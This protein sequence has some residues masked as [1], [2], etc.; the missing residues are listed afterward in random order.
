MML[1]AV[2]ATFEKESLASLVVKAFVAG[3]QGVLVQSDSTG[4]RVGTPFDFRNG[5]A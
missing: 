2:K 3:Q 1:T 4:L 5:Y